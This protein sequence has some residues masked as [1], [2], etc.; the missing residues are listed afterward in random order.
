MVF[1]SDKIRLESSDHMCWRDLDLRVA[2]AADR[3]GKGLMSDSHS[4]SRV[5]G[6]CSKFNLQV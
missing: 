6:I 4:E 2:C 1:H 3:D 5:S